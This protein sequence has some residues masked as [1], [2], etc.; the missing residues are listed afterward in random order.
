M[1]QNYHFDDPYL[2]RIW[3]KVAVLRERLVQEQ[4][5]SG[6]SVKK[7]PWQSMDPNKKLEVAL[8]AVEEMIIFQMKSFIA[9]RKTFLTLFLSRHFGASSFS[10]NEMRPLYANSTILLKL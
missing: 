7:S 6:F 4:I 1:S 3:G 9:V 8:D 2:D 5:E 10:S